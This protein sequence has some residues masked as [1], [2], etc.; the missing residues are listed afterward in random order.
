MWT[1]KLVTRVTRSRGRIA[2]IVMLLFAA[3]SIGAQPTG[4]TDLTGIKVQIG[5]M[6]AFTGGGR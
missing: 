2:I 1:Q 5:L 3:S 6:N 4:P